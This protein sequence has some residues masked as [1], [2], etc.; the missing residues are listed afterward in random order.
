M[1]VAA[2]AGWYIMDVTPHPVFIGPAGF[3][4]RSS[5]NHGRTKAPTLVQY[6]LLRAVPF[7]LENT[8]TSP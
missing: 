4:G 7:Q 3:A 8:H 2:A 5:V 1:H 6:S